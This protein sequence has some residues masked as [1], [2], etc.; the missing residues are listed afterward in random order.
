MR[1]IAVVVAIYC[2]G[3]AVADPC[4]KDKDRIVLTSQAVK[5]TSCTD[6]TVYA[7]PFHKYIEVR[8]FYAD[9]PTRGKATMGIRVHGVGDIELYTGKITFRN[10]SCFGVFLGAPTQSSWFHLTAHPDTYTNQTLIRLQVAG[11]HHQQFEPCM[12]VDLPGIH[13]TIR[14]SYS[15]TTTSG[16]TQV[17]WSV[18]SN[19]PW[20]LDTRV[21]I[22][23]AQHKQLATN[24]TKHAD[25]ITQLLLQKHLVATHHTRIS[26]IWNV[27]YMSLFVSGLIVYM[28]CWEKRIL[29]KTHI[30]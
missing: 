21:S 3:L 5:D 12:H 4:V 22:L 14:L 17:I 26:S 20:N 16:L 7:T 10:H 18:Q 19:S 15:A 29:Q 2:L 13:K 23:E 28:R 9:K 24:I 27:F 1:V 6:S 25:T 11:T 30:L 8:R